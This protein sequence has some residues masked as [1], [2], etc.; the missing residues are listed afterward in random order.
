MA[1]DV[2]AGVRDKDAAV[3]GDRQAARFGQSRLVGRTTIAA[4]AGQA[5]ARDDD[6]TAARHNLPDAGGNAIHKIKIPGAV[7]AHA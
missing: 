3:P 4:E 6:N 1:D 2:I 5:V 7:D